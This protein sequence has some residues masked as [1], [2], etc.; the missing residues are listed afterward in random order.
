MYK[1]QAPWVL[2]FTSLPAEGSRAAE[3]QAGEGGS[4]LDQECLVLSHDSGQDIESE[5]WCPESVPRRRGMSTR[6]TGGKAREEAM[7]L[8]CSLPAGNHVVRPLG[9]GTQ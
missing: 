9:E 2:V 5:G 4:R 3:G 7:T 8:G 1:E 6:R